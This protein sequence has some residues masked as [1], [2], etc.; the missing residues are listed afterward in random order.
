MQSLK[1]YVKD[2]QNDTWVLPLFGAYKKPFFAA[3][4]LGFLTFFFASAL[5]F[6]SGYL[7]SASAVVFSVLVLHIPLICVEVFGLG[8][9]IV[10]YFERLTSHDWVFRVTTLLRTKLYTTLEAQGIFKRAKLRLGDTLELLTEDIGHIQDLYL[11]SVFPIVIASVVYIVLAIALGFLSVPLMLVWIGALGAGIIIFPLASIALCASRQHAIKLYTHELYESLSDNIQGA[12]DW[13]YSG[14]SEEY[15]TSIKETAAARS[16]IQSWLTTFNHLRDFALQACFL[17]VILAIIFW[18]ADT[19]GSPS[20]AYTDS[21]N[22]IAAFSLAFFPLIDAFVIVPQAACSG[23][24]KLTTIKRLNSLSAPTSHDEH[25]TPYNATEQ[26]N[27]SPQDFD[28]ALHD[29]HFSYTSPNDETQQ[30]LTCTLEIPQGTKLMITGASGVGKTTLSMLIR[31]DLTPDSGTISL[32]GIP[33]ANFGDSIAKYICHISQDPHLFDLTIAENIRLAHAQAS[34]EDIWAA[35]EVVGLKALVETLPDQLNTCLGENAYAFSGG[36]RQRLALARAL[37]SQA[38]ILLL[39][40]AT[41]GLDPKTE[42]EVL[43]LIL[44][45][46]S[47]KTIILITH[48]VCMAHAFDAIAHLQNG[49]LAYCEAFDTLMTSNASFKTLYELDSAN[50]M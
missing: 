14:R 30:A 21:L 38:P 12:S 39:D 31:G 19:F 46:W 4:L 22:W 10:N 1:Q 35:L 33:I 16:K 18:A 24:E 43:S 26:Q 20:H 47:D 42:S 28:L 15:L 50:D 23:F 41:S 49:T 13:L 45:A 44:S 25:S 36:Q 2:L 8:R 34:D 6:T 48:H 9:P 27:L 5:M 17:I 3:I 32:G 7:V 40:E 29:V 11:R 37:V